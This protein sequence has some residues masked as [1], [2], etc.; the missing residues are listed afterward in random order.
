MIEYPAIAE[1]SAVILTIYFLFFPI[2]SL[3]YSKNIFLVAFIL[4]IIRTLLYINFLFFGVTI[5]LAV[6]ENFWSFIFLIISLI[7]L[8]FSLSYMMV[9]IEYILRIGEIL[10]KVIKPISP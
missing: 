6:I 2:V 4:P 7:S 9:Y 10:G 5:I 3:L 1:S 8:P